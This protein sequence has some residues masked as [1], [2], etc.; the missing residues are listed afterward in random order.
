MFRHVQAGQGWNTVVLKSGHL[1]SVGQ[2]KGHPARSMRHRTDIDDFDVHEGETVSDEAIDAR[3][4]VDV[5]RR[6][7]SEDFASGPKVLMKIVSQ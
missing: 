1:L 7:G 5:P 2:S 6:P 4:N 3:T